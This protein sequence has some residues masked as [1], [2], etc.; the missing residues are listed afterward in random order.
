M[1]DPELTPAALRTVPEDSALG[2]AVQ[3]LIMSASG[4]RKVFAASGNEDGKEEEIGDADAWLMAAAAA[5]FLKFLESETGRPASACTIAL[6]MDTRPTG[7]ALADPV[8]RVF[9]SAG[10]AVCHLFIASAPEIM[11]YAGRTPQVDAFVYFT[12]SHNP[13]G[14]NGIKFGLGNGGVLSGPQAAALKSIF[15]GVA[16]DI[17]LVRSIVADA[18]AASPVAISAVLHS[19]EQRKQDAL[20]TYLSFAREVLTGLED[21]RE[22]IDLITGLRDAVSRAQFGVVAELNGSARTCSIDRLFLAE[23]G[24]KVHAENSLPR[25]IAHRIVPEGE[26]LDPCR[27][28]L[29]EQYRKNP[30]FQLGYVP[31][32]DGDRGNLVIMSED[33]KS[34]HALHAQDVFALS[35]VAELSWL[36]YTGVL[37]RHASP[38]TGKKVAIAVNGPT[39]LRVEEIAA[40]FGAHVFRAEVGEANVVNL[41]T[42]LREQGYVVRILGEGS[43]G[44]NITHPSRVRDPISTIGSLIKLLFAPAASSAT[45]QTP[46]QI[47]YDVRNIS[48]NDYK[49]SDGDSAPHIAQIV[50]TLPPYTTTSAYEGRAVLKIRSSSH[51]ALKS[52]YEKLFAKRFQADRKWLQKRFGISGYEE[53]NYEGTEERYGSGPAFRTGDERGGLKMLF[54]DGGGA[55]C[56]F[57][58]MRGSGTEPVFRIMADIKG[59]DSEGEALLLSWHARLVREADAQTSR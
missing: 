21:P 20:Q 48:R 44:G 42:R 3:N 47:W 49:D 40:L 29:T 1:G 19:V 51:A 53:V 32:N 27:S 4:W 16:A 12:A 38:G 31:D 22:Q 7:P 28:I 14:H 41:A 26:S 6:G 33:G 46:L 15:T 39:S 54:T 34:A 13:V 35:C 57:V 59:K 11:A 37:T 24:L 52:S 9:V 50:A 58:W 8:I 43:N 23:L 56:A 30:G 55:P 2:A 5:S 10:V 18:A 25:Q 45:G 36:V 17:A